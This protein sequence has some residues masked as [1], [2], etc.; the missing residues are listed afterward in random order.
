[1]NPPEKRNGVIKTCQTGSLGFD[2][3]W[4]LSILDKMSSAS[5]PK[6]GAV[7]P[8]QISVGTDTRTTDRHYIN[9]TCCNRDNYNFSPC[10]SYR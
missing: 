10:S 5:V 2:S 7:N 8:M 4:A 6:E 3:R 9:E 1:M